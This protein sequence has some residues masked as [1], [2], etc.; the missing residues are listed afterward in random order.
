MSP[1]GM[2]GGGDDGCSLWDHPPFI[3][4]VTVPPRQRPARLKPRCSVPTRQNQ[5]GGDP[6]VSAEDHRA[7]HVHPEEPQVRQG[8]HWCGSPP[9]WRWG[10]G[11][12]R[13]RG[14]DPALSA[15]ANGRAA[16]GRAARGSRTS[17]GGASHGTD[18]KPRRGASGRHHRRPPSAPRRG[19]TSVAGARA[20]LSCPLPRAPTLVPSRMLAPPP[21]TCTRT[22]GDGAVG[23][24]K[25]SRLRAL[26]QLAA[27]VAGWLQGGGFGE[28][29]AGMGSGNIPSLA[30]RGPSRLGSAQ[31]RASGKPL[32]APSRHRALSARHGAGRSGERRTQRAP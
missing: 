24:C 9:G 17:P 7:V 25:Y 11:G 22:L 16:H 2:G 8:G 21:S 5:H 10:G 4:G 6:A 32:A 30:S 12:E 26:T 1:G 14:P 28:A 15:A 20:T 18:G 29:T 13:Y 27:R 31:G 3:V 19:V 23:S